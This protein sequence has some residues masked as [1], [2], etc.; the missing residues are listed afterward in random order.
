M[1][2]ESTGLRD[3]SG[4]AKFTK[5]GGG[6]GFTLFEMLV[7]LTI[8]TIAMAALYRTFATGQRAVEIVRSHG[9]A[10]V[11]AQSLLAEASANR[12]KPS[13]RIRGRTSGLGWTVTSSPEEGAFAYIDQSENWQMYR[14]VATVFY[15]NGRRVEL[16]TLKLARATE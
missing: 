15:S 10:L 9:D 16:N 12:A 3:A 11:I 1:N 5:I 14:I 13:R 7:G 6:D 8:L 2:C 4:R